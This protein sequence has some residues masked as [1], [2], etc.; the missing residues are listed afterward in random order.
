MLS[1]ILN[2]LEL[3]ANSRGIKDYENK[4]EDVLTKILSEPKTSLSKNKIQTLEKILIN[5]D[6]KFL[7][8]KQ[9]RSEKIFTI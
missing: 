5:Q 2:E 7:N 4:S 3:V 9:K 8:H 1:L 6:I